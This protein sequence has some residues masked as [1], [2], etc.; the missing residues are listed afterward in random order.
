MYVYADVYVYSYAFVYVFF[1]INSDS[2]DTTL[3][4]NYTWHNRY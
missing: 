2:E 1:K 4:F 3:I